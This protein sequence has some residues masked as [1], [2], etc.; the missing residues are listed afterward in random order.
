M[1]HLKNRF[2]LF[3][4]YDEEEKFDI[5]YEEIKLSPLSQAINVL[6]SQ[7]KNK[8]LKEAIQDPEL[9]K[10]ALFKML[11]S[12]DTRPSEELTVKEKMKRIANKLYCKRMEEKFQKRL[13]ELNKDK[14]GVDK[15][16]GYNPM[17]QDFVILYIMKKKAE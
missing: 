13:E 1:E 2:K 16:E 6:R 7:S 4:E 11:E 14:S 15:I 10:F 3:Q 12:K 9:L 8:S 17:R 5:T